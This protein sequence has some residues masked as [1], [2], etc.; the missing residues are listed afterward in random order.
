MKGVAD[1]AVMAA[2]KAERVS[3]SHQRT[4]QLRHIPSWAV[5]FLVA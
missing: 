2:G 1:A 5:T 4:Y 3:G